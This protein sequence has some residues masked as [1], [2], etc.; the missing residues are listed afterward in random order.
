MTVSSYCEPDAYAEF[1]S[2]LFHFQ[3]GV[4]GGGTEY[5]SIYN[6]HP[7]MK[8]VRAIRS[9]NLS[10]SFGTEKPSTLNVTIKRCRSVSSSA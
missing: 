1:G 5:K 8:D 3:K 9:V 4:A 7:G 2:K 10:S 6:Y